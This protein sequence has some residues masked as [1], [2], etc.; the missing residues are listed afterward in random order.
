MAGP[1]IIPVF[2]PQQGC[3]YQCIY[4]LRE[5]VGGGQAEPS[6]DAEALV[7]AACRFFQ[8][9][10]VK[11]AD[12]LAFYGGTFTMLPAERQ[13][14]LL[15]AAVKQRENGFIQGI[16]LS[17]RPDAIDSDACARLAYYR[18]GLV[19]LGVQSL[20]R[21]VLAASGRGYEPHCVEQSQQRLQ[22]AGI[23]VAFQLM[24]GLPEQNWRS[25]LQTAR[26]TCR[27]R[28]AGVRIYPLLVFK[29]TGLHAALV[30]GA[31]TPLTLAAAVA[32]ASYWRRAFQAA[33]IPVFRMGLQL[34]DAELQKVAA[35]PWHASFSALVAA[36]DRR[37]VLDRHLDGCGAVAGQW[38]LAMHAAADVQALQQD[39][40]NLLKLLGNYHNIDFCLTRGGCAGAV[41]GAMCK[42]T[43]KN[44]HF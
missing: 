14:Q 9:Q 25:V 44:K 15:E 3:P 13:E 4:C 6:L 36:H 7:E 10:G 28:P 26:E 39:K 42:F 17:T 18:V 22:R 41:V 43:E 32:Q 11:A 12:E 40:A 24:L 5:V 21:A 29:G 35:G 30:Q 23:S 27:L 19:E 31:Y 2:I 33:G 1:K 8:Q 34:A 16:R 20:D 37:A 38:R